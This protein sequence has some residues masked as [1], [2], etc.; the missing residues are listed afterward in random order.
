MVVIKD[1]NDTDGDGTPD[2]IDAAPVAATAARLEIVK[3]AQ[4]IQ[5]LIYGDVG[6]AYTLEEVTS[7]PATQWNNPTAVTLS[8]SPHMV[9]L[10]SPATATFWRA[11]IP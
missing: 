5:I 10:P 8:A 1:S 9:D 7:L 4:G 6:R 2:I 3:T 11:R